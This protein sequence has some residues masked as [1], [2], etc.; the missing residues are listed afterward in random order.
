[1]TLVMGRH[2]V[3]LLCQ[4]T[5]LS[6]LSNRTT[7]VSRIQGQV[8]LYWWRRRNCW[9]DPIWGMQR[10]TRSGRRDSASIS[11]TIASIK[12]PMEMQIK[13]AAGNV[14][15]QD[16]PAYTHGWV[17][18]NVT[19]R[20]SQPNM[21]FLK[22]IFPTHSRGIWGLVWRVPKGFLIWTSFRGCTRLSKIWL[23]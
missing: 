17:H 23:A 21:F 2:M 3:H 1:M 14:G 12:I 9:K 7:Q 19:I 4:E 22:K 15:T 20:V 8:Q 18:D 13:S 6:L 11:S 16:G 5:L 10:Q